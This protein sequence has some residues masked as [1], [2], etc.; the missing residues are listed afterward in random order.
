MT[1]H[2]LEVLNLAAERPSRLELLAARHAQEFIDRRLDYAVD[3]LF[4]SCLIKMA[5]DDYLLVVSVDHLITDG[6]SNEI[7][8]RELWDMYRADGTQQPAIP[9]PQASSRSSSVNRLPRAIGVSFFRYSWIGSAWII[10][11]VISAA[12]QESTTDR[13]RV[14]AVLRGCN[15]ENGLRGIKK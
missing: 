12:E 10:A 6:L 11:S 2:A 4:D 13:S 5:D 3:P 7:L 1:E 8:K 15:H 14:R 9:S